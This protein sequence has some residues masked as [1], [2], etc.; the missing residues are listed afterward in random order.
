MCMLGIEPRSP[1]K[2]VNDHLT[3][4]T[5]TPAPVHLAT[6]EKLFRKVASTTHAQ[7]WG[8]VMYI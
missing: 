4:E 8:K 2:T 3:A 6:F 5:S 7:H 1:R